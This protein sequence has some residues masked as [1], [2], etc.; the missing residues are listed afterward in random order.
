MEPSK[1][2]YT[3]VAAA[4]ILACAGMVSGVQSII[5]YG[6]IL[7]MLLVGCCVLYVAMRLPICASQPSPHTN[8]H[9][10]HL[11]VSFMWS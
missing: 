3:A 5:L 9:M 7:F 1:R 8:N 11:H 2:V 10:M 6:K 4:T